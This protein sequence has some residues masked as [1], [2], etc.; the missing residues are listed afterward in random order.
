MFS[1]AYDAEANIL[2]IS[3]EGFYSLADV[4]ALAASIDG[5]ARR[6]SAIRN[7][8]DVL[9]ESLN[10]PVQAEDVANAM[11]EIVKAGMAL[12][13]GHAAV[14]V[15]SFL[16]KAQVERTLIHPRLKAFMSLESAQEW[17]ASKAGTK[18]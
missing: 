8:F 2:R 18:A 5:T 9:V 15:A 17:L 14:V 11:P 4:P 16:N 3:V 13:S 7:D 1:I 12:T 6:A 10:F